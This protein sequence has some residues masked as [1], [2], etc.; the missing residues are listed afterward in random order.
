MLL[1][2]LAML[3][4]RD[5]VWAQSLGSGSG[6]GIAF[7]RAAHLK[8]G[9]NLSMWYAQASDYSAARLTTYTTVEDFRLVR[10][11]GFDHARLSINPEPLML[12]GRADALDP[13]AIAR[14]DKTVAEITATGLIV[15]LDIHPEMPYVEALGQGDDSV[16]KFLSFWKV[17]AAHY[18]KTDPAQVYLEVLNE[19]HM[20]DSYRWAGIQSKAVAAIRSAAPRHTIIATGNHW[21][22]VEGLLELEPVRDPNVIYSF[23]DYDPMTFT[24]QGA[25]WSSG[26]LKTLK[27]VPYPATPEN[28]GPLVRKAKDDETK[29]RL[30]EYGAEHWDAERVGVEIAKAAE[31]GR[32]HRVPVWCGEFGVYKRYAEPAARAAWLRDMR[33]ALEADHIGW[34]MWD[35]QGS[36]A[37]VNKVDGT[38]TADARVIE[39]LGLKDAKQ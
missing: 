38:A 16:V 32:Q 30:T 15:I 2:G 12:E 20:E 29:Q 39:A 25:S 11:L 24:H 14:L 6:S 18:A 19:P 26:Y 4:G 37:L 17:F 1:F 9:I 33:V 5:C 21:G 35:Y 22:G 27:E 13:E 7:F 23:H 10:S 34:S 3:A 28:V 8:R 31:W 36:F